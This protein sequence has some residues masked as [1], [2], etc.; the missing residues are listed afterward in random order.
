MVGLVN[1]YLISIIGT[2]V[3][4]QLGQITI[5]DLAHF[6]YL[7]CLSVCLN[8]GSLLRFLSKYMQYPKNPNAAAPATA[9]SVVLES[10]FDVSKL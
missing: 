5:F 7:R 8:K 10:I 3:V 6:R 4:R 2:T 1:S 9:V